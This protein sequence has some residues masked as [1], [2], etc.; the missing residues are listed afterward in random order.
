MAQY[1]GKEIMALEEKIDQNVLALVHLIESRYLSGPDE[2]KAFDLTQ[3][4][5]YF[6]MDTIGD[7]SFGQPFGFLK[8]DKDMYDYLKTS[9]ESFPFFTMLSM[10]PAL[11]RILAWDTLQKYLPSAK[12]QMGFGRIMGFVSS[13]A[14]PGQ[15]LMSF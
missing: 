12:D 14:S 10:F 13:R 3:K 11:V 8:E 5:Q 9:A 2:T 15:L 6:T 4:S 1:G 7:I